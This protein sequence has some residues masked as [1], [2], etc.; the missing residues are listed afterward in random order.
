MGHIQIAP[1]LKIMLPDNRLKQ[2]LQCLGF[3][4]VVTA[5][6]TLSALTAA[7]AQTPEPT[8]DEATEELERPQATPRSGLQPTTLDAA[9]VQDREFRQRQEATFKQQ[10]G[11]FRFQNDSPAPILE[12]DSSQPLHQGA[13]Q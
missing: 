12:R 9:E 5:L 7:H 4:V 11:T 1:M 8:A 6:A 2:G 3:T 13:D 10:E